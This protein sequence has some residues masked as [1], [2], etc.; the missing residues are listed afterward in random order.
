MLQN[1]KVLITGATGGIGQAIVELF[2]REG[3]NII[4]SGTNEAILEKLSTQNIKAIKCDL[5]DHKA[6]EDLVS[7]AADIDIA[8]Y[9]AGITKDNLAL[10][11]KAEQWLEVIQINLNACFIFNQAV[12]KHMMR[13]KSGKIINMSS[14]IGSVGNLGQANYSA[15]KAGMEG[16]TKS[17]AIEAARYNILI[18]CIAPGFISTPMTDKLSDEYKDI[19][20]N[21]IP[22]NRIGHPDEIA[23][24]ALFLAS[25]NNT[26]ITGHTLHINGGMYMA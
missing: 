2:T 15:S 26:Y 14:V 12:I 3:A 21:K 19:I 20:K 24:A 4:I 13:K 23:H 22:L 10:R 18:N 16:M 17:L 6:I 5:H 7:Q 25:D 8:I 1:K 11:M 9:N